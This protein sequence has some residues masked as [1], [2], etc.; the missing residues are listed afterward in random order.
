[1]QRKEHHV[2]PNPNGGWD[3]KR[4]GAQRASVHGD[5]KA[6][7]ERRTREISRNQGTELIIHGK[8]GKNPTFRQSR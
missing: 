3:G 4:N 6:D 7:V 8:D 5:T 1:M 2:V